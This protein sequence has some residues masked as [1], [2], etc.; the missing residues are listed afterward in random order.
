MRE[1]LERRGKGV[2]LT[3]TRYVGMK[4][5][6][7]SDFF[8]LNLNSF[9]V[10]IYTDVCKRFVCSRLCHLYAWYPQGTRRQH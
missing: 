4:L 2:G 8:I 7:I 1:T 10:V 5:L 9:I 6:T 3:K